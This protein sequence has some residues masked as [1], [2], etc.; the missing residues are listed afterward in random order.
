MV[1]DHNRAALGVTVE[2]IETSQR[3][4]NGTMRRYVVAKKHEWSLSWDNLPSRRSPVKN[5][6]VGLTTVDDGWAGEDIENFHNTMDSAFKIRIKGGDDE[7][8]SVVDPV[9]EEYTVMITDFGKEIIKRG[10]VD[11]WNLNI[12][13]TEV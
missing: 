12:T 6:Q 8:V 10:V 7:F 4:A 11:L 5:G 3:M 1:T 2:R 9:V 13:L